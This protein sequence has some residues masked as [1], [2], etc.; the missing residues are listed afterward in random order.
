MKFKKN[1][2]FQLGPPYRPNQYLGD[3][4][5]ISLKIDDPPPISCSSDSTKSKQNV[6]VFDFSLD[7]LATICTKP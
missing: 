1:A 2:Q 6:D 5:F 7:L 4:Y 3:Y